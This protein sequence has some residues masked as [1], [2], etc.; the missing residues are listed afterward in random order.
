MRESTVVQCTVE[1]TVGFI[2]CILC[3][4]S[5]FD[6]DQQNWLALTRKVHP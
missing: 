1:N 5:I 4:V 2:L 3:I 6:Y